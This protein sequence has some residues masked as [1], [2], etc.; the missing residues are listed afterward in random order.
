MKTLVKIIV[1]LFL[2]GWVAYATSCKK[3]DVPPSIKTAA[4]TNI[5]FN[6]ATS[7]GEIT[8]D[9]GSAITV[10]GICWS[11]NANPTTAD[12]KTTD[13][14]KS[15]TFT[16]NMTNLNSTTTYHVRAYATNSKGTAYGNDISF[17][18]PVDK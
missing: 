11:T 4:V 14:T 7:G 8:S 18:T 13:G 16:S 5:E 2:G 9:G 15:G 1:I 3:D 17:I 10:S 12:A 6:A